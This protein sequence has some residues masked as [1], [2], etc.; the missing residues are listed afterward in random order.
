M[1][2]MRESLAYTQCTLHISADE[3]N[4]GETAIHWENKA[5][6]WTP[7]SAFHSARYLIPQFKILSCNTTS[8]PNRNNAE[9]TWHREAKAAPSDTV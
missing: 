8:K 1:I 7:H 5:V 2:G 9:I 4:S 6:L 3:K